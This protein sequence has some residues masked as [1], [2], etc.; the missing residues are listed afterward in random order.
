MSQG[1]GQTVSQTAGM[2]EL[3]FF[4][5]EY[6][7]VNGREA[8]FDTLCAL[9]KE[10][11]VELSP[12]LF[13]RCC[14]ASRPAEVVDEIVKA[15]GGKVA[16]I[17]ALKKTAEAQMEEFLRDSAEINPVLP[18]LLDAARKRTIHPVAVSAW[19]RESAEALLS[20][21][22]LEGMDLE[23]FD[24]HDPVFPRADHWLRMIKNRKKGP[25]PSMAVV[26]SYPACK[27]ALTAGVACIAVPD[28]FSAAADFSGARV[29]LDSLGELPPDEILERV[30]RR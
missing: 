5:L 26:A 19:S 3:I 11:K 2:R 16:G 24:S 18:D 20:R 1:E 27:G 13:S 15:H 28:R 17:D 12:A 10:K 25:V 4:E 7:A 21:L 14:A 9:F 23:A 29:L 30:S 6:V 22:G 8:L